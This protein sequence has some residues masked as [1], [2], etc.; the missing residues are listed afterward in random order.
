MNDLI[1]I[2]NPF[3]FR[4]A[5][6]RTAL[7]ETG[8]VWFCATDVFLALEIEWRGQTSL[9]NYPVNWVMVRN[10]RTTKGD[11]ETYFISEPAV[12][13]L[14]FRSNKPEAEELANYICE[15]ILP[16]LRRQGFIG[17]LDS[18]QRLSLSRQ[19]LDVA[20]RLTETKDAFLHRLLK[21][22]L[23]NLCNLMGI[24]MPALELLGKDYKQEELPL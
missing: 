5:E 20:T 21:V 12:W 8:Q 6:V 11:R 15:D 14:L 13:R 24:T 7:D 16:A 17:Q 23:R 18:R 3:S 4:S 10:F 2:R 19:V 22:E 1:D 9:K